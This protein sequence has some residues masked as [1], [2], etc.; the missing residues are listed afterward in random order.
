MELDRERHSFFWKLLL[1]RSAPSCLQCRRR[2]LAIAPAR[3]YP[4][5]GNG[6][7]AIAEGRRRKAQ[8]NCKRRVYRQIGIREKRRSMAVRIMSSRL[9]G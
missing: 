3:A 2:A 8:D 1:W 5:T 4:P 9:T 7:N 6:R